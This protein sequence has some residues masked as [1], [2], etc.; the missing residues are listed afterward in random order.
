LARRAVNE[1]LGD[2]GRP[3]AEALVTRVVN[4]TPCGGG[5]AHE[6][7]DLVSTFSS[8][9]LALPPNGLA[10]VS[11]IDR[12]RAGT[13]VRRCQARALSVRPDTD[14]AS[15][16]RR[17]LLDCRGTT[18]R[19]DKAPLSS[20]RALP[21]PEQRFGMTAVATGALWFVAVRM[22]HLLP[23]T[24]GLIHDL[25]ER[26]DS[27]VRSSTEFGDHLDLADDGL[28]E[29]SEIIGGYLVLQVLTGAHLLDRVAVQKT[30][31]HSK[32][33]HT[34]GPRGLHISITR[35]LD[36]ISLI[37]H[38]GIEDRLFRKRRSREASRRPFGRQLVQSNPISDGEGRSC[39]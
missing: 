9:L 11:W 32:A 34:S 25:R 24:F 4:P 15:G 30:P 36:C 13:P 5:Q 8:G 27:E 22:R 33:R 29:S 23:L 39:R 21:N 1:P 7:C 19:T 16:R 35:D 14:S 10:V 28:I 6:S 20:T 26:S 18:C 31:P 3:M 12:R 2:E 38:Y 37:Q 17:R